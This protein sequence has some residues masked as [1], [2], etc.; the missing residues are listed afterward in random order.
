M[1]DPNVDSPASIEAA[2]LL[3]SDESQYITRVLVRLNDCLFEFNFVL[4]FFQRCVE[5]SWSVPNLPTDL[6]KMIGSDYLDF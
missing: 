4:L 1:A 6:I 5:E 2:D 3:K